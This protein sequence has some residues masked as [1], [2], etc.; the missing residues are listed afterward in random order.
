MI[1]RKIKKLIV[2]LFSIILF[3]DIQAQEK[4]AEPGSDLERQCIS[5]RQI[6]K[7][8]V[9][10]DQNVL[11]Y[12]RGGSVYHNMLLRR[13]TTLRRENRFMYESRTGGLCRM[14]NIRVLTSNMM[15]G[16]LLGG[17]FCPL[18]KFNKLSDEDVEA[19]KMAT[20]GKPPKANPL[21]MP[22][23]Q[24]VNANDDEE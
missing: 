15:G 6:R 20:K 1:N 18:G 22:D 13:C 9:I 17:I 2:L 24:E 14:D 3:K 10:D 8:Q 11:F 21:P 12:M 7:T 4:T 16:G 19:F 23:P 5:V